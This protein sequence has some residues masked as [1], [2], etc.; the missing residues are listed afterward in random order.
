MSR[1]GFIGQ[2][3]PLDHTPNQSPSTVP[4]ATRS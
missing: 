2:K 3:I 4:R 1:A